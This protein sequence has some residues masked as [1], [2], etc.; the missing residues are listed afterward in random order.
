M[1][2][3]IVN[4]TPHPIRI[5]HPETPDRIDDL[6]T[7][8][9]QEIAPSGTV[10]RLA[11]ID[12]GTWEIFCG[13]PIEGVEYGHAHDLPQP[14]EGIRYVVSLALALGQQGREDLLVPYGEVRN[15]DGTV[16]GCRVLAQVAG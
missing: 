2:S 14:A 5:Y 16:V 9:L 7:G 8:L 3:E 6:T 1:A 11:T 15:S 12:L 10:A 4:L 13:V